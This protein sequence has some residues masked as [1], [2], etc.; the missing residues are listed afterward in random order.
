MPDSS[1]FWK[2]NTP[3]FFQ[4]PGDPIDTSGLLDAPCMRGLVLFRT[5]GSLGIPK[6]VGLT[7]EALLE[8]ARAVNDFLGVTAID[9]WLRVLPIFHVGGFGIHARAWLSRAEVTVDDGKWIPERFVSTC[10]T[11]GITLTSLV[12]AQVFDLVTANRRVPNSLRAVIVG[13]AALPREVWNRAVELGWPLLTSYGLTEAASQ[14]A[15]LRPGDSDPSELTV[16]PHWQTRI[17]AG[18]RLELCGPAMFSCY[19]HREPDKSWRRVE[20][21]D[22]FETGDRVALGTDDDRTVLRFLCRDDRRVKILGEWV[23]LDWFESQ[24]ERWVREHDATGE[25]RVLAVPDERCGHRL[26]LEHT[27]GFP[28]HGVIAAMNAVVPGYSRIT[29]AIE[30]A[31]IRRS[32]LGKPVA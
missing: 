13:G 24:V 11:R 28:C 2:G 27:H 9:R 14:V 4:N 29:E 3:E 8:S 7:R 26:V 32:P 10:A 22:W 25:A 16:L 1:G 12:P 15:T 31:A 6:V 21:G 19:F 18:G 20:A 17:S 23:D 5:S 30:V